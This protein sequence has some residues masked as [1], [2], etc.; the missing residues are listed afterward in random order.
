MTILLPIAVLLLVFSGL[1]LWTKKSGVLAFR[2]YYSLFCLS[3]VIHLAF[4]YRWHFIGL[5]T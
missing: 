2:I 1:K 5:H 4:L 3:A